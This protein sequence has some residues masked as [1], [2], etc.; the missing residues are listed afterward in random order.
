[1]HFDRVLNNG[2]ERQSISQ[3]FWNEARAITIR[4]NIIIL[5]PGTVIMAGQVV[6][7]TFLIL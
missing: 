2:W 7:Q 4:G 3:G 5:V 6:P 1:M